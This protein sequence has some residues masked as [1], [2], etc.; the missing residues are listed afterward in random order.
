MEGGGG[1]GL[2][3]LRG[4]NFCVDCATWLP[5]QVKSVFRRTRYHFDHVLWKA[6]DFHFGFVRM[7][8]QPNSFPTLW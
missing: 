5:L 7:A 3:M 4:E 8:R 6:A 1:G 2:L